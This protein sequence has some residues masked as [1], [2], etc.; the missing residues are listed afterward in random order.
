MVG[1]T[2]E[3]GR[4]DLAADPSAVAGLRSGAVELFPHLQAAPFIARAGVRAATADGLP[5][6]GPSQRSGVHLAVGARRNG[7]LFAPL[8]ARLILD[9]L[10]G[11]RSPYAASMSAARPL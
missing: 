2:M 6:V 5:L 3:I 8:I 7:W 11:R 9:E 1:A 10:S 4:T